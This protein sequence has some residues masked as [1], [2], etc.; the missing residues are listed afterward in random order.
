MNAP[1]PELLDWLDYLAAERGLARNSLAAYR[2]DLSPSDGESRA[3]RSARPPKEICSRRFARC[4]PPANRRVRWR[5]GS[6]RCAGSTPGSRPP[7]RSETTPPHVSSPPRCG[8][9]FRT[10]SM[11]A[12]SSGCSAHRTV[13]SREERATSR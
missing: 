11:G 3:R 5:D 4:A 2:R 1:D 12:T 8:R 7:A 10:F 13:P 6:W 9:R